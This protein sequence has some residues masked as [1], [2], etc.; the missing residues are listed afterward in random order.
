MCPFEACS[1]YHSRYGPLDRSAAQGDLCRKAPAR[2]LP[3]QA[4]CQLPAQPT[5]VWVEPPSTGLPRLR[6]ALRCPLR[7]I[8]PSYEE[9]LV[10]LRV[11][12]F[13]VGQLLGMVNLPRAWAREEGRGAGLARGRSGL[14]RAG[15]ATTSYPFPAL[16]RSRPG[17]PILH[18]L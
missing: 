18:S 16:E 8:A 2:R 6:G 13:S 11:E 17:N 3:G 10:K 5:M 14:V 15:P 12:L 1:G 7:S 4:A 9:S